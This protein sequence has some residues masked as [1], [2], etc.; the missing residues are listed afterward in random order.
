[1][2]EMSISPTPFTYNC[3]NFPLQLTLSYDDNSMQ[4][5][6][7]TLVQILNCVIIK[8]DMWSYAIHFLVFMFDTSRD[9]AHAVLYN[10]EYLKLP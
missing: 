6:N 10:N 2:H 4:F 8:S 5:S 7:Y 1:M 9:V 3:T